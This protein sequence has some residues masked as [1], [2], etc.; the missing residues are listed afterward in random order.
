MFVKA[1]N[2]QDIVK[3]WAYDYYDNRLGGVI[4]FR[5]Q[6]GFS[7]NDENLMGDLNEDGI[8]NI[9]DIVMII[10]ILAEITYYHSCSS[11]SSSSSKLVLLFI[12]TKPENHG[13]NKNEALL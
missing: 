11:S 3:F 12:V 10:N 6:T 7:Q 2:G 9:N 13:N 5:Y 8:I 1:A 4:S